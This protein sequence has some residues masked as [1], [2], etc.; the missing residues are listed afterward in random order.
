MKYRDIVNLFPHLPKLMRHRMLLRFFRCTP[1]IK[2]EIRRYL[3]TEEFPSYRV[4]ISVEDKDITLS[5]RSLVNNY[6]MTVLDAYLFIDNF[7]QPHA[8]KQEL[9]NSLI[10]IRVG[11][12]RPKFDVEYLR[13]NVDPEVKRYAEQLEQRMEQEAQTL[14]KEAGAIENKD[15]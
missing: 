6:R 13:A 4:V 8:P 7:L 10:A 15:F 5:V 3:D 12:G 2:A 14:E 1:E 9:L 11:E